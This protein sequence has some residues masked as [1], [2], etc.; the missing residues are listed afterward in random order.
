V[1]RREFVSLLGG[2]AVVWPLHA[3]ARQRRVADRA[4]GEIRARTEYRGSKGDSPRA[5][6]VT[7][8]TRGRRR[9][10]TGLKP[11]LCAN[12]IE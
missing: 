3:T 10:M 5:G 8:A 4:A 9:A 1:K 6:A 2:A 12:R 7:A 11:M